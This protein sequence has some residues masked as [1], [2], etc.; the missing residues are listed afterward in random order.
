MKY[1]SLLILLLL[2]SCK[3]N[4]SIKR[5]LFLGSWEYSSINNKDQFKNKT[6]H[7]NLLKDKNKIVGSYCSIS[8]NGTKIDCFKGIENNVTGEIEN[9]TLFVDFKS[10]WENS[11]GKAKIYFDKK[12]Q[13]IWELGKCEGELYLPIK[14]ILRKEIE[15]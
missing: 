9:D 7:L 5:E 11:K 13:L 15:K 10:S 14:V 4:D 6:F 8:R 12:S 2:F 3:K 1:F